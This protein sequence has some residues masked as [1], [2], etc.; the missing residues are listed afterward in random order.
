MRY[1][2][3]SLMLPWPLV[4]IVGSM[5]CGSSS[6]GGQPLQ[7]GMRFCQLSWTAHAESN[8]P[9]NPRAS[10]PTDDCGTLP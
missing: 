7:A 6:T 4:M 2:T 9:A 10:T 5:S 1:N 3:V 8:P